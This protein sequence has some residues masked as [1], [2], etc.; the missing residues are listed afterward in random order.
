MPIRKRYESVLLKKQVAR[1]QYFWPRI[2]EAMA[3]RLDYCFRA[4]SATVPYWKI[5]DELMYL[6]VEGARPTSTKPA[7][8]FKGPI[9]GRFMHKHYGGSAFL[10]TN[11][12]NQWYGPYAQKQQLLSKALESIPAPEDETLEEA[13]RWAGRVAHT[14]VLDGSQRLKTRKQMTGEWIIY[15]VHKGQNYYLDIAKHAEHQQDEQ[16]LFDRLKKQCAW[17]FP[18]AFEE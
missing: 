16:M 3:L 12:I 13:W 11:L 7:E 4:R 14:V 1:D 9:L 6:E 2:S 8:P 18:F 17:E 15:Y 5:I 10:A